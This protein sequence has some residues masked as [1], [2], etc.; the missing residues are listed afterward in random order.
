MYTTKLDATALVT[1]AK[2]VLIQT[3][4]GAMLHIAWHT[5]NS[6]ESVWAVLKRGVHG[7]FHY[8]S[9]KHLDRY[10]DEFTFRLNAGKVSRHTTERLDSFVS[11]VAGKR[12]TYKR[13]TKGSTWF[14]DGSLQVAEIV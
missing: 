5:R 9:K 11:L 2:F 10:V 8:V 3:P 7:T 13:L 14:D 12:I 1:D 4:H 6:I